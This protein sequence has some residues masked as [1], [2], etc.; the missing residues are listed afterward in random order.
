MAEKV[1][2]KG[3]LSLVQVQIFPGVGGQRGQ[4]WNF[5]M[6]TIFTI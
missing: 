2:V 3:D 6:V 5:S 1:S 4:P